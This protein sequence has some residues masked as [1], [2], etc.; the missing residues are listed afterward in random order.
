MK[1]KTKMEEEERQYLLNG[2]MGGDG[3]YG[4][5]ALPFLLPSTPSEH[6]KFLDSALPPVP[7]ERG[8]SEM[9]DEQ[10]G[11]NKGGGDMGGDVGEEEGED[12]SDLE[13]EAGRADDR[14]DTKRGDDSD[15]G[16]SSKKK[17]SKR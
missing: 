1:K 11:E 7:Q 6:K 4:S 13:K 12:W 2:S 5:P 14:K 3:R 17:A 10:E 16:R 8:E 9:G 15:D